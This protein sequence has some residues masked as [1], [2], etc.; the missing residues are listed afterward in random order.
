MVRS[1]ATFFLAL[2]ALRAT[3]FLAPYAPFAQVVIGIVFQLILLMA[4][5]YLFHFNKRE[6]QSPRRQYVLA[7][8]GVSV[9]C[10]SLGI[11]FF[12]FRLVTG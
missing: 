12:V 2:I 4:G 5:S 10:N 6:A 11:A 1:V 7:L 8:L 3:I 9:A